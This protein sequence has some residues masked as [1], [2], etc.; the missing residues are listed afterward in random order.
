MVR[1]Y[2]YMTACGLCEAEFSS[3]AKE[4]LLKRDPR[5]L[6]DDVKRPWRTERMLELVAK[7]EE[8]LHWCEPPVISPNITASLINTTFGPTA[9]IGCPSKHLAQPTRAW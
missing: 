2:R 9:H 1:E 7:P 4:N 6:E 3:Y 5:S 8:S